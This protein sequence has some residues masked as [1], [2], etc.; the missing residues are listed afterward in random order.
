M[1]NVHGL[2]DFDNGMVAMSDVN[3]LFHDA[4]VQFASGNVMV[5]D[6][7]RFALDVCEIWVKE[8]RLDPSSGRSCHR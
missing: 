4:P 2:F 1:E 5:E 6:S 7:G 8:I 3:F